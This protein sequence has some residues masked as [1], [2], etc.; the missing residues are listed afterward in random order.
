MNPPPTELNPHLILPVGTQVVALVEVRGAHGAVVHPRGAVG[1]VVQAPADYWHAYRV[2][3]PDEFEAS[4][5][6]NELA[7]LSHYN[8]PDAALAGNAVDR[9]AQYNLFQPVI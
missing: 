6:R 3:F 8:S 2:R 5:R 4:F 9:L 1:V 7:I